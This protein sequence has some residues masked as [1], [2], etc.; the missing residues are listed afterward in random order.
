M[1][2]LNISSYVYI[3]SF[4][5]YGLLKRLSNFALF[6]SPRGEDILGITYL[7]PVTLCSYPA[8]WSG[9]SAVVVETGQGAF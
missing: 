4:M 3:V 5:T 8:A 1:T 7:K 6:S 9:G 2:S